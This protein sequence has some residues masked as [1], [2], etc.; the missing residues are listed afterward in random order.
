MW[1]WRWEGDKVVIFKLRLGIV[2]KV[3]ALDL[4]KEQNFVIW[5]AHSNFVLL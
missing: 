4:N 3:N 1:E 5:E 2:S